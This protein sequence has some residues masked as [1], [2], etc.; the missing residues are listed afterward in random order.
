MSNKQLY[1]SGLSWKVLVVYMTF[2]EEFS[3]FINICHSFAFCHWL[4]IVLCHLSLTPNT[5]MNGN[6]VFRNRFPWYCDIYKWTFKD[7]TFSI[8]FVSI[9]C[10]S[11]VKIFIMLNLSHLSKIIS[12]IL[13]FWCVL[14]LCRNLYYTPQPPNL[15]LITKQRWKRSQDKRW[16]IFKT[17][18]KYNDS[19]VSMFKF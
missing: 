16:H 10:H 4:R 7:C 1:H 13:S 9:S 15:Q 12:L 3:I 6:S 19:L 14:H 2:H 5:K 11:Q 18:G 17:T 8:C